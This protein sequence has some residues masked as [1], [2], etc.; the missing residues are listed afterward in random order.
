V[1][2]CLLPAYGHMLLAHTLGNA[3]YGAYILSW[4]F[5]VIDVTRKNNVNYMNQ[6]YVC[7]VM[8]DGWQ[9]GR[10]ILVSNLI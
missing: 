10:Q 5:L 1:L 6:V 7:L 8:H 3:S 2:Q 4:S 9:L